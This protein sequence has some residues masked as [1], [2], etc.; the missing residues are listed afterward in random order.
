MPADLPVEPVI[1]RLLKVRA[2]SNKPAS[3]SPL[4]GNVLDFI[5]SGIAIAV[6]PSLISL[7][8]R[9]APSMEPGSDTLEMC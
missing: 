1:E 8:C 7:Q 2:I 9:V 6:P 4:V 5:R 3:A